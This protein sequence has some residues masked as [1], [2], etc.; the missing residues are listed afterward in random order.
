M[1]GLGAV[2]SIAGMGLNAV[3]TLAGGGAAASAL[4]AQAPAD[5]LAAIYAA[6]QL[7][8][9]GNEA[10]ASSQ[11]AAM[12]SSTRKKMVEGSLVARAAADGGSATD[13]TTTQLGAQIEN[14]GEFHKLLN[15]YQGESRKAGYDS[16]AENALRRGVNQVNS[17]LYKA[18]V[19]DMTTPLSAAGGFMS[20]VGHLFGNDNSDKENPGRRR[21]LIL[22]SATSMFRRFGRNNLTVG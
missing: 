14:V 13:T 19:M 2:T 5:Y 17:S 22:D 12:D 9:Q 4:R 18:R 8:D 21:D 6:Q 15:I 11:R 16:E 20:G 3:G 1:A 7:R 10:L